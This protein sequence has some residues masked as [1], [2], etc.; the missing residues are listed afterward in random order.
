MRIGHGL[1][2]H[3]LVAGR[4]LLLGG[5][6]IAHSRGLEGHSDA[7]VLLHA[8]AD[9]LLGALGE[10]DLGLHF[11][12]SDERWRDVASRE[13]LERVRAKMCA[14][15]FS[16]EYLDAT[17]VAEAPRLAPQ[18]E[19]IERSLAGL[20]G[21]DASRVNLKL[22]SADGL[23]ALGRGEG[24]AADAIVLLRDA[25]ETEAMAEAG[26]AGPAGKDGG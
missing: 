10:G 16:I 23:G 4:A 9:A 25:Q 24:I 3:R 15:G 8:V 6:R 11:P 22:K 5:V 7:D 26:R 13:I 21:C 19:E 12:S 18:R 14:R 20:L 2:A 17:I 1:D